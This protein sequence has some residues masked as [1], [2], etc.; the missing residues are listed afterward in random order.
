MYTDRETC[1]HD[2][3]PKPDHVGLNYF[4]CWSDPSDVIKD[5]LKCPDVF[6]TRKN[7]RDSLSYN[8]RN[9]KSSHIVTYN[10]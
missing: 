1:H 7:K 2:R 3:H 6:V 5:D 8:R 4:L 10:K 9:K